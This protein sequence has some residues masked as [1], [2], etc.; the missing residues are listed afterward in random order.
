MNFDISKADTHTIIKINVEK[1]DSQ[2]APE[3]KSHILMA[4]KSG[5]TKLII[6][7]A[8][9][10]YCDSSGLSALLVANRLCRDGGGML[11]ISGLQE[12]VMKLVTI[13]QLHNVLNISP[14]IS[15]AE[16]LIAAGDSEE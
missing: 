14:S 4:N 7:L 3:L 8:P 6:D 15:E 13:S 5:E 10:K 9:T 12:P 11:V 1:L 16:E 2:H